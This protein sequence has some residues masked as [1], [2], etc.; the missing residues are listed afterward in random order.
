MK[1]PWL[2][3]SVPPEYMNGVKSNS[4]GWGMVPVTVTL[5]TC[6]WNTS[7]LPRGDGTH[8]IP[9]KAAVRRA[10]R[11]TLGDWVTLSYILRI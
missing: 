3:V 10:E 8:F 7:L 2:Y 6:V 4:V 5:G 9:L 1:N 11:V